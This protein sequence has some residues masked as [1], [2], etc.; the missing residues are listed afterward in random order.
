MP[1]DA[2]GMNGIV[3]R[4][5]SRSPHL[6]SEIWGTQHST[7]VISVHTVASS[8]DFAHYVLGYFA[9]YLPNLK[10]YVYG[11]FGR[12]TTGVGLLP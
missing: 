1:D 9:G 8:C 12:C 4:S 2:A 10:C 11:P 5:G 3:M 6:N 7:S